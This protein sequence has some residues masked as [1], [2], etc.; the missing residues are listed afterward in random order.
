[1]NILKSIKEELLTY[2]IGL[3]L[4]IDGIGKLFMFKPYVEGTAAFGYQA[5]I[6]PILGTYLTVSTILLFFKRSS[7]A[8]AVLITGY[9]GGAVATHILSGVGSWVF[10]LGFGVAMWVAL[11]LRKDQITVTLLDSLKF[12]SKQ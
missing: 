5:N 9:L 12:W 1:M 11:L 10:P 7:T 8:G 3:F 6:L 2:F 4:L